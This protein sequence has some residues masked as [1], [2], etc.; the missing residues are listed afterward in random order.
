MRVVEGNEGRV[1]EMWTQSQEGRHI[2]VVFVVWHS[3]GWSVRNEAMMGTVPK[4]SFQH[5]KPLDYR[6]RCQGGSESNSPGA[7]GS[8]SPGLKLKL[9]RKGSATCCAQGIGGVDI[10]K[11]LD[12]FVVS[13][14]LEGKIEN[15]QLEVPKKLLGASGGKTNDKDKDDWQNWHF[16]QESGIL[17]MVSTLKISTLQECSKMWCATHTSDGVEYTGHLTHTQCPRSHT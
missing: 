1:A 11:T 9:R 2:F 5:Q 6:L 16:K 4:K 3:E 7:V 14:A 17:K 10:R 13:E 15:K 8:V 12:H